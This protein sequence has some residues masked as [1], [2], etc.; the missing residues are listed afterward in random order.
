MISH[1]AKTHFNEMLR[2]SMAEVL[3]SAGRAEVSLLPDLQLQGEGQ[4]VMLTVASYSFNLMIFLYF[5]VDD[6]IRARVAALQ[7]RDAD[8]LTDRELRDALSE[9]GNLCCG[10]LNREIGRVFPHAGLSTPNILDR[11][12]VEH[13]RLLN[14]AHLQHFRVEDQGALLRHA[15]LC[16][17]ARGEV[18]FSWEAA[19]EPEH[20]AGELELF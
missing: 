8:S 19:P 20:T 5:E 16:V 4:V 15:T 1:R 10:A 2:R 18:D 12:C 14:H 13:V 3:G 6:V 7:G 11:R 17:C 9:R